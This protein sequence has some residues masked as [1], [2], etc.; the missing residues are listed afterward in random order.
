MSE[1]ERNTTGV[2]MVQLLF[3]H[4]PKSPT[5]KQLREALEKYLGDLGEVPYA[6]ASMES[7]GDMFMFPVP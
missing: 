7:T 4:R 5:T 6:E 1:T 2:M 3:R